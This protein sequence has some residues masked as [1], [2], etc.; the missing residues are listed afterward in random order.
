MHVVPCGPGAIANAACGRCFGRA[1]NARHPL[2]LPPRPAS[3]LR[4][5]RRPGWLIGLIGTDRLPSRRNSF[6]VKDKPTTLLKLVPLYP[7]ASQMAVQQETAK[8]S[9]E[10]IYRKHRTPNRTCTN[11]HQNLRLVCVSWDPAFLQ[12]YPAKFQQFP[13]LRRRSVVDCNHRN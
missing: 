13:L 3:R 8:Y 12:H 10:P 2:D 4:V 6:L 5:Y 9:S 1:K 7:M 11:P